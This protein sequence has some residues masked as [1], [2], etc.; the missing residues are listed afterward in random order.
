MSVRLVAMET[1]KYNGT[2]FMAQLVHSHF[3]ARPDAEIIFVPAGTGNEI[4]EVRLGTS[5]TYKLYFAQIYVYQ[6]LIHIY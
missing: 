6:E 3:S 2:K 1:D 4:A 5:Q